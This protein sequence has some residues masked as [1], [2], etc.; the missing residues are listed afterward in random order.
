MMY[1]PTEWL[2]RFRTARANISQDVLRHFFAHVIQFE[3]LTDN[4][5]K[6]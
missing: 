5:E 1:L 2:N 3:A 4:G 6:T